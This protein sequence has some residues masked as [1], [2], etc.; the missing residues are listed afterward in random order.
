MIGHPMHR[1]AASVL[2]KLGGDPRGFVARQ[3]TPKIGSNADLIITMTTEHRERVLELV[4]R[5]LH[6]TFTLIEAAQLAEKFGPENISDLTAL[7][8]HLKAADSLDISDPIGQ[9]PEFF[10][11]VGCQ[12]ADLLP[13]VLELC[14]RSVARAPN[15]LIRDSS[16]SPP[17]E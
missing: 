15:S 10:E 7:R 13:P 2:E 17:T 12:I 1:D 9:S 6:R 11:T 14:R 4:P 5:L 16:P 8:P 3:L